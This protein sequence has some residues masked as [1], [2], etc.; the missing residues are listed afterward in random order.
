VC[1]FRRSAAGDE[2]WR[3]LGLVQVSR[4]MTC[5]FPRVACIMCSPHTHT[6]TPSTHTHTRTAR[7]LAQLQQ[8]DQARQAQPRL[9]APARRRVAPELARLPHYK[10]NLSTLYMYVFLG[11]RHPRSA[12][13]SHLM[14]LLRERGKE[15]RARSAHSWR[16]GCGGGGRY[17]GLALW[18]VPSPNRYMALS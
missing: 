10:H 5:I 12:S 3:A 15:V 11:A 13:D 8:A 6:H 9:S 14:M 17:F 2:P 1:G 4:G 18:R 7:N 16:A